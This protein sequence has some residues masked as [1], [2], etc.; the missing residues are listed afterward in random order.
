[1][2]LAYLDLLAIGLG[3]GESAT[4]AANERC[5]WVEDALLAGVE[6]DAIER[7][8]RA[9]L[10]GAFPVFDD[11]PS[12]SVWRCSCVDEAFVF[13]TVGAGGMVDSGNSKLAG[14]SKSNS[15]GHNNPARISKTPAP[16]NRCFSAS[17]KVVLSSV[18]RLCMISD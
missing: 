8:S 11:A 10:L 13:A 4:N 1:M 16:T 17:F 5:S 18:Y 15:S 2:D 3:S 6:T 14:C 12:D 9:E 7:L